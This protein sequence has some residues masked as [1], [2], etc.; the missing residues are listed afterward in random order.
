MARQVLTASEDSEGLVYLYTHNT[1]HYLIDSSDIGKYTAYSSIGGD[2]NHDRYS[3]I[4]TFIRDE[5]S[6]TETQNSTIYIYPL[7]VGLDEDISWEINGVKETFAKENSGILAIRITESQNK[8]IMQ[9]EIIIVSQGKQFIIPLKYAYFNGSLHQYIIGIEA[10]I[11]LMDQLTQQ[12]NNIYKTENGAGFYLS[13]R[14]VKSFVARKYLY[15]EEG[16]YKLMHNEPN[17]IIGILKQQ[18]LQVGDFAYFN[19]NFLGPIKIWE[20]RYPTG[21]KSDNK[22]MELNYPDL[23]LR[24][25]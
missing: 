12:G 14:T 22:Y 8:E 1:T 3:Y 7:G 20:I 21:I 19:G 2:I 25:S 23:T 5:K 18:G 9:P 15:G 11:F 13:K 10:G 17:Y 16:N 24:Y 6:T 4:P